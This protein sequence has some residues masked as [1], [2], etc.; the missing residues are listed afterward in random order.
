MKARNSEIADDPLVSFH[1]INGERFA[2]PKDFSKML[3]FGD[4]D[5]VYR[6]SRPRFHSMLL[7]QLRQIDIEVEYDCEVNE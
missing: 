6:H 1:H 2:G 7:E 3:Y 5:K 4:A